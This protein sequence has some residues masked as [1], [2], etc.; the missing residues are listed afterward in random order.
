MSVNSRPGEGQA[1]RRFDLRRTGANRAEGWME[2]DFHHFGVA[3]GHD[4]GRIRT[5]EVWSERYPWQTCPGAAVP[6]QGLVGKPLVARASDIGAMID[7]RL[8]CTHLFDLA[9]LTSAFIVAGAEHRAYEALVSDRVRHSAEPH[10][11]TPVFGQGTAQLW[12]DGVQVVQWQLDG[13]CIIAPEVPPG[14]TLGKGFRE[15]TQAL[16]VEQAEFAFVLR[17][18]ILIAGGRTLDHDRFASAAQMQL[19]ALCHTFQ[20]AQ[21]QQALRCVGSTRDYSRNPDGMLARS[22]NGR[23]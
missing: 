16:D 17:R 12:R 11:L 8:Q 22:G 6:L 1:R 14:Q 2:D 10:Y 4:D 5:V 15:W 7:M 3:L 19:P 23:E 21:R 13:D 9:G 20:P 18:A